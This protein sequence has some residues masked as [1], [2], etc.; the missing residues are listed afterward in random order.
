MGGVRKATDMR[1]YPPGSTSCARV[2]GKYELAVIQTTHVDRERLLVHLTTTIAHSIGRVDQRAV[3]G[4]P[5]LRYRS[6]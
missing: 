2:F 4:L 1:R 3:P 5:S 6:P